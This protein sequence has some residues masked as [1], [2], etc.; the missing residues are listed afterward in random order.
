MMVLEQKH[1]RSIEGAIM[2]T[3]TAVNQGTG[4]IN[5]HRP[6]CADIKRTSRGSSV[7]DIEVTEGLKDIVMDI[8]PPSD[9]E[10]DEAEWEGQSGDIEI[11]P[12]CPSLTT[13]PKADKPVKIAHKTE[14]EI[15]STDELLNGI[16]AYCSGNYENGWCDLVIKT[17]EDADIIKIIGRAT[18]LRGAIWKLRKELS[19]YAAHRANIQATKF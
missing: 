6:G 4:S 18:T 7:W 17:M 14:R 1:E 12:C 2:I 16:Q 11:M 9:F 5:I 15:W 8:Y 10:Y 19:A 3:V 13:A